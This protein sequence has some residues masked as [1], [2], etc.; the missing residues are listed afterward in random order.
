MS[1]TCEKNIIEYVQ[2]AEQH[3]NYLNDEI[4]DL[5]REINIIK[6]EYDQ[7]KYAL[8][9][10][11]EFIK[12]VKKEIRDIDCKPREFFYSIKVLNKLD[13]IE[14]DI[15]KELLNIMYESEVK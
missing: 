8:L 13:E 12:Y 4:K 14:N 1:C 10:Q 2:Y 6:N 11:R 15:D 7:H 5:K 3:I 9:A